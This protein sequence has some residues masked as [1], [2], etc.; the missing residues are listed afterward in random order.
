M[1]IDKV[2]KREQ[3]INT[4][5]HLFAT[6][7]FEG[8]SIRDIAAAAGVN[9]AMINYYFGSKEKLFEAMV[10]FK[11]AYTRGAF[12][13]ITKTD[14]LT[15]IEKIERVIDLYVQKLFTNREFH[16]VLHH[17]IMLNQRIEL[18]EAITN[19]I[20]R[21]GVIIRSI[22]EEGIKR[23]E[24]KKVDAA[25]TVASL[26]GTINQLLLSKRI[27]NKLLDEEDKNYVPYEDAV[28]IKRVSQHL[29]QM[30]RSH[31]LREKL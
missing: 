16:K 27:C 20:G 30:M 19:I 6:R 3:I 1:S 5:I 29:K 28:F 15:A 11:A 18:G 13:E 2:D 23:K 24:F 10:E 17:E 26:S 4:A 14:G 25:L 7:G 22:I 31:L 8:S 21:N 9:I 12:D